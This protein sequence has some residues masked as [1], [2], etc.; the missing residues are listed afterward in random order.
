MKEVHTS[1][2]TQELLNREAILQKQI[3]Q[4]EKVL[5]CNIEGRLK[6]MKRGNKFYYALRDYDSSK[7]IPIYQYISCDNLKIA[8][9]IA[10]RD[11]CCEVYRYLLVQ[12][13]AIEALI[14]ADDD[15][16]NT[17]Y[18]NMIAGRRHLVPP[19]IGTAQQKLEAWKNEKY[20]QNTM[21]PENLLH[22]TERGEHVRSKSEEM[23]AN[24]LYSMK[25]YIDYKYERPLVLRVNGR[26]E[27]IY[28]DFTLINLRTG[29]MFVLEHVSRLDVPGYH[30]KFVWKH[31]AYLENG[32][33]QKG[34]V[35]YSFE[36]EGQPFTLK[37]IKKLV[38]DIVIG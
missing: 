31:N 26:N 5:Q 32:L 13:E 19:L 12:R 34:M 6:V 28:P 23:I 18:T 10:L 20:E 35:L 1:R 25:D 4:V 33:I 3:L 30:D 14:K 15:S 17:C 21:Y 29:D 37:H 36:S 9:Q 22:E 27:V 2:L 7:D 24:Y 38:K 11:Y 8:Q 16:I